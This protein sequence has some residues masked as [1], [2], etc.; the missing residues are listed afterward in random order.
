VTSFRL[1]VITVIASVIG[2]A[3]GMISATK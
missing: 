1:F 2:I 3:I